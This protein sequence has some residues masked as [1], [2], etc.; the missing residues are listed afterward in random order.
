VFAA[1]GFYSKS[2]H[3]IT[4]AHLRSRLDTVRELMLPDKP[5]SESEFFEIWV[6][7]DPTILCARGENKHGLPKYIPFDNDDGTLFSC[8]RKLAGW[9]H[10]KRERDFLKELFQRKPHLLK[11]A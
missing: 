11:K 7:N 9:H 6:A 3:G 5:L 2:G 8:D 4:R 10:R 1:A